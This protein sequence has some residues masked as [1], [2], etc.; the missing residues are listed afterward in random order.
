MG[1]SPSKI[2]EKELSKSTLNEINMEELEEHLA[3]NF[4]YKFLTINNTIHM[5]KIIK[6]LDFTKL[7]PYNITFPTKSKYQMKMLF[8][9]NTNIYN[10]TDINSNSNIGKQV[11]NIISK[12]RNLMIAHKKIIFDNVN[13]IDTFNE[14]YDKDK[15]DN[16]IEELNKLIEIENLKISEAKLDDI[17]IIYNNINTLH[18]ELN[19]LINNKL[20]FHEKNENKKKLK[21]Q[22]GNISLF[23]ICT[24]HLFF[25]EEKIEIEN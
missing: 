14:N 7:C 15:N 6:V 3:I 24:D 19:P 22:L 23:F 11:L 18:N 16:N 10:M 9:Y 21:N 4:F 25:N 2:D 17:P 8:F 5:T 1:L 13:E 20:I 12:I